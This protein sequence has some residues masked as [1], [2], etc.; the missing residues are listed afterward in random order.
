MNTPLRSVKTHK[1]Q[2]VQDVRTPPPCQADAMRVFRA[3]AS[4]F[5][6]CAEC[7]EESA[8]I[9]TIR[10]RPPQDLSLGGGWGKEHYEAQEV[11]HKYVAF[12]PTLPWTRGLVAACDSF[13]TCTLTCCL[14]NSTTL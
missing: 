2:H 7:G 9:F 14:R 8:A 11:Q 3:H 13:A 1:Q 10:R 5:S 4:T 6:I 12:V